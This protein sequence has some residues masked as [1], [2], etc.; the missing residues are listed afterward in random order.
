MK[1]FL[2]ILGIIFGSFLVLVLAFFGYVWYQSNQPKYVYQRAVA[3]ELQPFADN[4]Y[5]AVKF[6]A[7]KSNRLDFEI[8]SRYFV[9]Y[10]LHMRNPRSDTLKEYK[11]EY[12]HLQ[13]YD[14]DQNLK[15]RTI[16][17]IPIL[18]QKGYDINRYEIRAGV[19]YVLDG[20]DYIYIPVFRRGDESRKREAFLINLETE[21]LVNLLPSGEL[22]NPYSEMLDDA[23]YISNLAP[24]VYKKYGVHIDWSSHKRKF[25]PVVDSDGKSKINL[26]SSRFK[27]EYPKV[28]QML[29]SSKSSFVL[30]RQ[31]VVSD[32][33]YFNTL[34]EWFAPVGE[35]KLNLVIKEFGT[36]EQTPIK[37]YSDFLEYRKTHPKEEESTDVTKE[38]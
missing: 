25:E 18:K 30:A 13:V 32:E 5:L 36:D 2:K 17:L 1:R 21:E 14:L 31:E 34:L 38:D 27:E 20:K 4:K 24:V 7:G 15:Q 16:D 33:A 12:L 35:E 28:A 19:I 22:K 37:S 26:S 3:E 9:T 8:G 10:D 29:E 6:K 23:L 11:K